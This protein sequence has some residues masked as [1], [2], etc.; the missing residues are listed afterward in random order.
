MSETKFDEDK[1]AGYAQC[2]TKLENKVG[3]ILVLIKINK[4]NLQ[5]L[6]DIHAAINQYPYSRLMNL[7]CRRIITVRQMI[8]LQ[9][10][11][12]PK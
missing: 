6:R 8:C 4:S 12:I 3:G 2:V 11:M 1:T 10:P 7:I 9:K 5:K